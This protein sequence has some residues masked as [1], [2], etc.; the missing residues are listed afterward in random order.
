[1]AILSTLLTAIIIIV[2]ILLVLIV[3]VQRPKQ[4]GLGA[5]FGG[6][7]FDSALGAHTTDILQKITTYLAVIYFVCAVG[8]AIVKARQ[9]S[10]SPAKNVLEGVEN[11]EPEL[12]T[13]PPGISDLV[14]PQPGEMPAPVLNDGSGSGTGNFDLP[15]IDSP[16]GDTPPADKPQADTPAGDTP[17]TDSTEAA[18]ETSTPE[19]AP[20]D[21]PKPAQPEAEATPEAPKAPKAPKGEAPAAKGEGA[22]GGKG[23]Q[24]GE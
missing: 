5:A 16:A 23:G 10:A 7:A 20:A 19:P 8:L 11:R 15:G 21:T 24:K 17:A 12:P 3:L 4:E 13:M 2:S 14:P 22:Q 6:G 1:M 9:F 18:P